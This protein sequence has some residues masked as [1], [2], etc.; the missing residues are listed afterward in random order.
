[1]VRNPVKCVQ[2]LLPL[3]GFTLIVG[4]SPVRAQIEV[5]T[6]LPTTDDPV[7][8]ETWSKEI[9][10]AQRQFGG[11]VTRAIREAMI[12]RWK[13]D[14]ETFLAPPAFLR[15]RADDL[16]GT[17][18]LPASTESARLRLSRRKEDPPDTYRVAFE[19]R[20]CLMNW[21]LERTATYRDGVLIL[22]RA[23]VDYDESCY[24]RVYTIKTDQG[25]RLISY[26]GYQRS[27]EAGT[28][29]SFYNTE[30]TVTALPLLDPSARLP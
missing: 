7:A 11:D 10:A 8:W 21:S 9:D 19:A 17:W 28:A 14:K 1:M 6:Q 26:P 27:G 16:T 22:N 30:R 24:I 25:V 2:R 12:T 3:L 23:V 15:C 18:K 20:G 29:H 4:A 5:L 13:P